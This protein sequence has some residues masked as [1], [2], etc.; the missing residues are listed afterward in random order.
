MT[1]RAT[2]RSAN[3]PGLAVAEA[4][5][6]LLLAARPTSPPALEVVAS[7]DTPADWNKLASHESRRTV[8]ALVD[9]VPSTTGAWHER[10]R[11]S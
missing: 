8:P 6:R 1:K 5:A 10:P 9:F 7:N 3:T 11:S 4:V 2:I